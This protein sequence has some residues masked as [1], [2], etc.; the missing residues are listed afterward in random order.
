MSSRYEHRRRDVSRERDFRDRDRDRPRDRDY[1]DRDRRGGELRDA[2]RRH[3]RSRSPPHRGERDRRRDTRDYDRDRG[4]DRR[5]RG[6]RDD[7]R[8]DEPRY[9]RDRQIRGDAGRRD[10]RERQIDK[11]SRSVEQ[12]RVD[13]HP[14]TRE[15]TGHL[16]KSGRSRAETPGELRTSVRAQPNDPADGV[17]E[18]EA[19]DT[20]ND[21]DAAMMTMMGLSGFGST[22][23]V[24]GNQ[25]GTADVKKMRTWR[26]YMNRRGG[27]N[28]PLDK[29]K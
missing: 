5:D 29:I 10:D 14:E 7:R 25:E 21:D 17:E 13:E 27:F 18:G 15:L 12:R 20:T 8:R 9:E 28:R 1:R 26:Q 24:E 6:P 22:K 4:D 11:E 3:S 16:S 23:R 19:M 2:G